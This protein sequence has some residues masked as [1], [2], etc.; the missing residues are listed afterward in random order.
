M[1]KDPIEKEML[2]AGRAYLN[3]NLKASPEDYKL[4]QV[5]ALAAPTHT[6]MQQT[7]VLNVLRQEFRKR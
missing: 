6:A 2:R 4:K 7:N 1:S 5:L 3:A